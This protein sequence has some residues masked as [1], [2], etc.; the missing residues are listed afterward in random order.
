MRTLIDYRGVPH[1]ERRHLLA[2][3]L[4]PSDGERVPARRVMGRRAS[5]LRSHGA[6]N[7]VP[8]VCAFS[9][10]LTMV[11]HNQSLPA[12]AIKWQRVYGGTENDSLESL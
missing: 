12:P 3:I 9:G 4:S 10:L 2:R 5:R 1:H 8:L 11:S 7:L 6:K